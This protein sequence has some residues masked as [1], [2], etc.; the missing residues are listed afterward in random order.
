MQSTVGCKHRDP[1]FAHWN[2]GEISLRLVYM[3]HYTYIRIVVVFDRHIPA[4]L[5]ASHA[6]LI[7]AH[8]HTWWSP[9]YYDGNMMKLLPTDLRLWL[10]YGSWQSSNPYK[11]VRTEGIQ[12]RNSIGKM[13]M[14]L[15]SRLKLNVLLLPK[16][17]AFLRSW[18]KI[19]VYKLQSIRLVGRSTRHL[20]SM[21]IDR[22]SA[23]PAL[24]YDI[25]LIISP[26]CCWND[27]ANF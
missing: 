2:A 14:P 24:L 6:H 3:C 25:Y 21:I 1:T 27:H 9:E 4:V 13:I 11:E 15:R 20:K 22:S 10:T 23:I 17:G 12:S 5:H 26:N 7:L 19:G 8:V 16:L 18:S